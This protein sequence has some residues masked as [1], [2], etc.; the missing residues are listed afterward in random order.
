MR[1]RSARSVAVATVVASMALATTSL[2]QWAE[3]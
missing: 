1:D 3:V 2:V